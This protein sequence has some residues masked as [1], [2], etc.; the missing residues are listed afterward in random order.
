MI[1]INQ[2][3]IRTRVLYIS[4]FLNIV[5]YIILFFLGDFRSQMIDFY[6]A[7]LPAFSTYFTIVYY[8]L[9]IK[10]SDTKD[11]ILLA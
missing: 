10:T 4:L 11:L 1:A 7:I 3:L 2:K 6:L 8:S 5:A 9:K